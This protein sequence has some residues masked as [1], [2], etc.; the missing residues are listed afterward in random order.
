MSNRPPNRLTF[1]K[2]RLETA[3]TN[4]SEAVKYQL[5]MGAPDEFTPF[6]SFQS[7]ITLSEIYTGTPNAYGLHINNYE[8]STDTAQ[9]SYIIQDTNGISEIPFLQVSSISTAPTVMFLAD[10]VSTS[11]LTISSLYLNGI[12]ID[13]ENGGSA[14]ATGPTGSAGSNGSAG[15]TQELMTLVEQTMQ[16]VTQLETLQQQ[17]A[18]TIAGLQQ[19]L[20]SA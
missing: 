11:L 19:Q 1:T 2:S 18:S 5:R 10:V 8:F 16:R 13:L 7:T 17:S 6:S 3:D 14:G 15:A 20:G 4:P 9:Y 12:L